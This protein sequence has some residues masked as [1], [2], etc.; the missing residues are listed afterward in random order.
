MLKVPFAVPRRHRKSDVARVAILAPAR[1]LE[2][3]SFGLSENGNFLGHFC[4][5]VDEKRRLGQRLGSLRGAPQ[6]PD[7]PSLST[8]QYLSILIHYVSIYY[9]YLFTLLETAKDAKMGVVDWP[10]S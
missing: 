8:Y 1:I 10:Q 9:L 3:W 7:P 2:P 5:D 4:D 6:P